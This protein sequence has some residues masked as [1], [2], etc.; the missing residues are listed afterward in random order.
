MTTKINRLEWRD[1]TP[2]EQA[3]LK[4][5]FRGEIGEIEMW[6]RRFVVSGHKVNEALT[7]LGLKEKLYK[8]QIDPRQYQFGRVSRNKKFHESVILPEE[9]YD[10]TR[11]Q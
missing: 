4:K 3:V 1:L 6:S 7:T 2:Q 11:I 10:N 8:Y 9:Y 5:E